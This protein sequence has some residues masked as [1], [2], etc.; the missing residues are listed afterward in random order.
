[1]PKVNGPVA[2]FTRQQAIANNRSELGPVEVNA[3]LRLRMV[4]DTGLLPLGDSYVLTPEGRIPLYQEAAGE[5]KVSLSSEIF[6]IPWH[7]AVPPD[8]ET[9]E[10]WVILRNKWGI[11]NEVRLRLLVIPASTIR[12]TA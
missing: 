10:A 6:H 11:Q 5:G 1:V 2:G 12:N 3:P 8:G 9:R 4:V 7:H